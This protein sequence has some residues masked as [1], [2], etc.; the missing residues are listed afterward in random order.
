MTGGEGLKAFVRKAMILL[1]G[2]LLIL[3]PGCGMAHKEAT[4]LRD[5]DNGRTVHL[6]VGSIL[7]L[8]LTSQPGTGY[9]WTVVQ[10]AE[11]LF[12]PVGEPHFENTAEKRIGGSGYQ[13]FQFKVVREGKDVLELGYQRSW[14][15]GVQPFRSFKIRI[16]V[17]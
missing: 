11:G 17:P 15:K 16:E 2:G 9:T 3:Q 12:V 5:E 6:A 7:T 8:K 4:L 1:I 10:P 13:I 14:E